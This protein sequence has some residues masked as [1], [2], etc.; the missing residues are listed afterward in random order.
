M[1]RFDTDYKYADR[2]SKA[3]YVWLK[4]GPILK[5]HI[6]DVGADECHLRQ[7]LPGVTSYYGIGLG[8]NPDRL[9][10]LEKEEI[11]FADNSFN[12]V[13]CLDVLEHLDNAHQVFDELCRVSR[14]YVVVSLPNP[15]AT[16]IAT[17]LAGHGRSK[18]PLKFYGLPPE[19]PADRYKWFFSMDEA[20]QFVRQRALLNGL[21]VVQIDHYEP[22]PAAD[23]L[24]RWRRA[25]M[26]A[27]FYRVMKLGPE[28][29]YVRAL[30]ALLRRITPS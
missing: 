6:L 22:A 17:L 24:R 23:L 28:N 20:E 2:E 5:E 4:Y 13:L 11:P 12:C 27:L 25:I 18:P 9:V 19:I 16:F 21:G 14:N 15:W 3:R 7:Y 1:Q 30:W 26:S 10:D 8:G 29:L